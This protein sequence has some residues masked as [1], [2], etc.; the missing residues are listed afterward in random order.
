MKKIAWIALVA[1]ILLATAAYITEINDLPGAVELRTFGF[2]GYI[3][4]ISAVAWFLL[5]RLYEWDKKT[6]APRA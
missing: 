4:I 3:L 2:I 6:D 1:G 5:R